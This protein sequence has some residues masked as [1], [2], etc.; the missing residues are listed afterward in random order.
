MHYKPC[1][2]PYD[3]GGGGGGGNRVQLSSFPSSK[4]FLCTRE[5]TKP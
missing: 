1:K 3:V 4:K 5:R 2:G